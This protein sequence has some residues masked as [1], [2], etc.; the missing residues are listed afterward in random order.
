VVRM[1]P[2]ALDLLHCVCMG[3]CSRMSFLFAVMI[4]W[5]ECKKQKNLRNASGK[6]PFI[7]GPLLF[8]NY[9]S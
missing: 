7:V 3:Y 2:V 6:M 1:L 5:V 9:I 8:K 4:N